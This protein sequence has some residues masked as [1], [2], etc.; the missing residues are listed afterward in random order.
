M[1]DNTS[2]PTTSSGDLPTT[3][4]KTFRS[5]AVANTV[6]IRARAETIS[7]YS[8][9]SRCPNRGTPPSAGRTMH[10][11][12]TATSRPQHR[13]RWAQAIG[14]APRI[15]RISKPG[16]PFGGCQFDVVDAPPGLAGVDQLGLVGGVDRLG[17]GVV[18]TIAARPDRWGDPE[19]GQSVGIGQ[20]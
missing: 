18:I 8:S 15:T 10:G 12:N 11:M 7:R 20:R 1:N 3:E 17:E 14:G 9:S 2:S 4:K 6:F 16:H 19:L 5:N 13:C